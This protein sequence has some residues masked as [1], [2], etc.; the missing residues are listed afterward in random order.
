[1]GSVVEC[2]PAGSGEAEDQFPVLTVVVLD[3]S[4]ATAISQAGIVYDVLNAGWIVE[5]LGAGGFCRDVLAASSHLTEL[6]TSEMVYFGALLYWFM[7]GMP[8]RMDA[9]RN[10]IP[11]ETLVAASVVRS[12]WDGGWVESLGVPLAEALVGTWEG[13]PS[14]PDGWS[15]IGLVHFEFRPD[16]T[17]SVGHDG[18]V[19][20]GLYWGDDTESVLRT[21][22]VGGPPPGSGWI[23]VL[24][25]HGTIQSGRLENITVKDAQLHFEL[26]N[27]WGEHPPYGPVIYD[28]TRIGT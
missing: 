20:G 3:R 6:P 21:Y 24:W 10:Q 4:G 25:E 9:D 15:E 26:W 23:T 5:T 2:V 16:G 13:V 7:E 14:V 18:E 8:E 12:V 11:C 22:Q 17:Y 19:S 28:L 27:D 1:L